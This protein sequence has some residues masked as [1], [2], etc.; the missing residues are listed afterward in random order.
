[1]IG[2]PGDP[3]L[4]AHRNLR[5]GYGFRR[6]VGAGGIAALHHAVKEPVC[7]LAMIRRN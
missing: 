5:L 1:V 3:F 4:S 6:Q 2:E 7:G